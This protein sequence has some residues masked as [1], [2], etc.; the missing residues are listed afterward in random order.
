MTE[1]MLEFTAEVIE[2]AIGELKN[3]SAPGSDGVPAQLLKRCKHVLA[4]PLASMWRRSLETGVVPSFYK[5]SLVT[6]LHKKENKITPSNYRP[7]SLTSHI[8]KVFERVIKKM[9]V[10]YL[11]QNGLISA[12]QHGCR[13]G[14]ST[15]TQLIAH[16]NDILV[17][18][19][20]GFD[21]DCI[22]LDYAKAFDKVDHALFV[23]KMK[24]FSIHPKL[25]KWIE[26]FLVDR[27][28]CVV[29]NGARSDEKS[30]ISGVPQGSV[31]G[32]APVLFII[33]I[34]DLEAVIQGS[35]MRFFADD[36]KISETITSR[37][38]QEILQE[39]LQSTLEWSKR[40]NMQLHEQKFELMVHRADP[41]E[42][43]WRAENVPFTAQL[44]TCTVSSEISLCETG[45]LRDLGIRLTSD[46]SWRTHIGSIVAKGRSSA[47]WVLS[48]FKSR[49]VDIMLTLYY[50][51]VRSHL[52]Y[53][54]LLWHPQTIGDIELVEGVQRSFT[55]RISG[56]NH[57]NY[58][59]RLKS[60]NLMSLQRRR[61]RY[62][63]IMMWKYLNKLVPNDIGAEFY[64]SSRRGMQAVLPSILRCRRRIITQYDSSFAVVG[65]KLW[66][67]LP[68]ELNQINDFDMFKGKLTKLVLTVPDRP[69]ILGYARANNN[70]L[71][72]V[73]PGHRDNSS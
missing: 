62:I 36:T 23:E 19:N 73:I 15:L 33:F 70:S 40:N 17:G 67:V 64:V 4:A 58:W 12:N 38:D 49:D 50:S 8:M 57:L 22:Y 47:S 24:R 26:S 68:A 41:M 72:E 60:L 43:L 9:L 11:E 13:S 21:L 54:S 18:W 48:V 29:V 34:N 31:L 25:L 14:R 16:V 44:Y 65:P 52:E 6:P 27:K 28:Q 20:N 32:P 37:D 5:L 56:M 61:E 46:L 59:D 63:I 45:E 39:D 3:N 10:N 55:A 53:C 42:S 1:A 7:V 69:P 71:V 30:V 66:N 2:A 51:F 35:T